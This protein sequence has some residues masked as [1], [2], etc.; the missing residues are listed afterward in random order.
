V[1]GRVCQRARRRRRRKSVQPDRQAVYLAAAGPNGYDCSGLTLTAWAAAGLGL[2]HYTKWQWQ[3]SRP[4][5]RAQL[6]PGDLVF[7]YSDLHHVGIYVG[8]GTIVHAP[9]SGD[10]VRMAPIDRGMPIAGYRR[11]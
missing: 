5:S 1:P 4:I 2:R 10:H 8:G 9:H 3:D 7:F 6:Q 11:P